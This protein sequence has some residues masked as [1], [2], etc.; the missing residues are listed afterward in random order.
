MCYIT[1]GKF[2]WKFAKKNGYLKGNGKHEVKF[3]KSKRL[4]LIWVA[5]ETLKEWFRP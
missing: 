2:W 1:L 5:K 3:V 4:G